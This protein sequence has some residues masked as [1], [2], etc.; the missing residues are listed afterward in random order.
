MGDA[1]EVPVGDPAKLADERRDASVSG[2]EGPLLPEDDLSDAVEE[3]FWSA[4]IDLRRS[5]RKELELGLR[6]GAGWLGW[7]G[8]D[9]ASGDKKEG[10]FGS[11][12]AA[13]FARDMRF[14]ESEIS[15]RAVSIAA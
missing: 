8:C 6:L 1:T 10:E 13:A 14:K 2:E 3:R 15:H 4:G 12:V 5:L 7:E 11:G 9:G